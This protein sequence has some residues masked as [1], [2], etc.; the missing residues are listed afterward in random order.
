MNA[1]TTNAA[2]NGE[3]TASTNNWDTAFGISF[4]N[5]NMAIAAQKSSP[6]SFTSDFV[7]PL[8]GKITVTANFGDWSLIGGGADL[9]HMNLPLISGT[10]STAT[11]KIEFAGSANIEVTLSYIPQPGAPNL[12]SL[13][14]QSKILQKDGS[15]T[16]KAP[17]SVMCVDLT[18]G[19]KYGIY[20]KKALEGWLMKN[21]GKFNHTFAAVDINMQADKGA[22]QWLKPTKLAY[23]VS[24]PVGKNKKLA[25][26][27]FGVLAMTED[28]VGENLTYDISPNIIPEGA[29]SGFLISRERFLS[30]I[31]ITNI[32][33]LFLNASRDDFEIDDSNTLIRNKSDLKFHDYVLDNGTE[34]TGTKLPAKK[35]TIELRATTLV[36]DIAE[37]SFPWDDGG[38]TVHLTYNAE[39]TLYM[40]KSS[41][42]Q[43]DVV[44]TPTLTT[45][46]TETSLQKW[47][48]IVVGIAEGI[49]FAV[50]G[51]AIGGALGPVAEDA[52]EAISDGA[53]AA[54][55]G[56]EGTTGLLEFSGDLPNSSEIENIDDLDSELD[57]ESSVEIKN[58]NNPSYKAKFANF[59]KKNWRKVLGMAIGGAVGA[60]FS[61]IPNILET[62][63]ERELKD[64]PTL[65]D[66]VDTAVNPTNWPNTKG[67]T[68]QSI[69][70]NGSLQIGLNLKSTS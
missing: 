55:K 25:D 49:G 14:V 50:V 70:L 53:S 15:S 47:T 35:F 7:D 48:D 5:A 69:S 9:V 65:N 1:I 67:Y 38:Y 52:G 32:N 57:N 31:L 60:V 23:A 64:M 45:T 13:K 58:S 44:G 10:L 30:K 16:Q 46:V 17:V 43:S 22:L 21:L 61:K 29:N 8:A 39:S 68:I 59:F 66:F 26:F 4:A 3:N 63:S 2:A 18:E 12:Q 11:S 62:Y 37:M 19:G 6:T 42:L 20:I 41:H 28:R 54:A 56:A 33:G 34:I 51:A 24:A 36:M 40:D 27:T